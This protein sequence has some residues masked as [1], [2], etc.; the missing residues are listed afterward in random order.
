MHPCDARPINALYHAT[1]GLGART[2]AEL[3]NCPG[4]WMLYGKLG[5]LA[6]EFDAGGPLDAT[7]Q[8]PAGSVN[9]TEWTDGRGRALARQTHARRE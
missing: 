2:T 9:S 7:D 3:R 8:I 4:R 1:G 5:Q 6:H